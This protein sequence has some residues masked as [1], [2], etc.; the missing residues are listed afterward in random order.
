MTTS[1]RPSSEHR[2]SVSRPGPTGLR[3]GMFATCVSRDSDPGLNKGKAKSLY[4]LLIT[5]SDVSSRNTKEGYPYRSALAD[6]LDC[7]KDTI[8][9][10]TKYLEHEIGLIRVERRKV[11]GQ[12]DQNDANEYQVFDQWLIHGTRPTPDTPPQLVARY[13][14]TILGFDVDAWIAE[15]APSFDLAGWRAAYEEGLRAQ[16]AKR[17][18]QR[19]KEALRRKPKKGGVAEQIPPRGS[20]TDSATGGGMSAALSRTSSLDPEP[21]DETAPSGRSP[22]E[23]RRASTGSREPSESGFAAAAKDSP[24]SSTDSPS[25]STRT[26]RLTADERKMRDAVLQLLPMDLR[27]AL[28]DVIPTNVS[29]GVV[30]CL[31]KGAPRERTPQQLVEYRLK[32]RWDRYWASRFYAGDLTPKVNGKQR[33]PFGP[34]LEMLKDTAECR[35]LTCEDRHDYVLGAPCRNCEMRKTDQAAD[36]ERERRAAQEDA[37]RQARRAA[38]KAAAEAASAAS[39]ASDAPAGP[40]PA[41]RTKTMVVDG[42]KASEWW[43]CVSCPASGRGEPPADGICRNCR[44]KQELAA[45]LA[46]RQAEVAARYEAPEEEFASAGPA[47]F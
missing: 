4:H 11:E 12:P 13:G 8:D 19:R 27:K 37:D 7:T 9:N 39:E 25:T 29:Q 28:G 32:P 30:A 3:F 26:P 42:P 41:P 23:P 40:V 33:K 2:P 36:R 1:R 38:E 47:P 24:S 6:A 15:H 10:A 17:E 44:E 34:L 20:G 21:Q 16:E 18:A 14:P 35:N 45:T 43:D 22:G 46:V 5:Y 31:A